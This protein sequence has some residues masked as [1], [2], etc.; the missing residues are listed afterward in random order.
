MFAQQ[1]HNACSYK[2]PKSTE[3]EGRR[4]GLNRWRSAKRWH[5][6]VLKILDPLRSNSLNVREF[7]SRSCSADVDDNHRSPKAE[8]ILADF[9][10]VRRMFC[11][12][13]TIGRTCYV[14]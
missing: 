5:A 4:N 1:Q 3:R 2:T 13:L 10:I 12:K 14:G 6:E 11:W 8:K 7:D 9:A